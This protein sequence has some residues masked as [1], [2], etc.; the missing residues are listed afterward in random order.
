MNEPGNYR[1]Y[2]QRLKGGGLRCDNN[3]RSIHYN[4]SHCQRVILGRRARE[5]NGEVA[6]EPGEMD[7]DSKQR[8][9]DQ[10][11]QDVSISRKR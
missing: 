2:T 11:R 8:G 5:T 10:R 1:D 6:R 9:S 7:G 3:K 4:N